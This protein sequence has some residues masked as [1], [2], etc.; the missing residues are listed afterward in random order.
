MFMP[1]NF[2]FILLKRFI[3]SIYF[4]PVTYVLI[5]EISIANTYAEI[6]DRFRLLYKV[7][8]EQYVYSL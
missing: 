5:L 8:N 4:C 2:V 6:I 7:N 3:V 1:T